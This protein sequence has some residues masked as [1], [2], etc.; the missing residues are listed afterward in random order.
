[1]TGVH[2]NIEDGCY[3]FEGERIPFA[4]VAERIEYYAVELVGRGKYPASYLDE[5]IGVPYGSQAAWVTMTSL[6]EDLIAAAAEQGETPVA[7]LSPP[8][9]GLEGHAVEVETVDRRMRKFIVEKTDEPIPRHFEVAGDTRRQAD[10]D[11]L[12]V[13]D[14]GDMR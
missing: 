7:G 8:L 10:Y 5:P 9:M 6:A 13:L 4:E 12:Q 1:M 11:Y 14:L 2:I 3:E